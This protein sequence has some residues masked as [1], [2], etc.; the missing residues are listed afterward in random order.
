MIDLYL[1]YSYI[2]L[3]GKSLFS[4]LNFAAF[5]FF[6]ILMI[7][8]YTSV[9]VTVY[10]MVNGISYIGDRSDLQPLG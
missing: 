9:V 2:K 7:L 4:G 5:L 1:V 10:E 8:G 3:S 6:G